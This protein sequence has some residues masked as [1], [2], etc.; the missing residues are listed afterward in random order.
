MPKN[1]R[2]SSDPETGAEPI[3]TPGGMAK[4]AA[5]E[6]R[7]ADGADIASTDMDA[8]PSNTAPVDARYPGS[9]SGLPVEPAPEAI[10]RL[11]GEVGSL[12]DQHLRLAAEFDNYRKRVARERAELSERAQAAFI[13]RL[14]D[15]L[16]DLDR[17]VASEPSA[18]N[19]G[20]LRDALL[21][22]DKKL[23]K[24][25]EAAGVER[26]DPVGEPFDPSQHEAVSTVPAPDASSDHTVSA[27]FQPGYRFKGQLVRPARVQVF[28]TQGAG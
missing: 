28:S 21:L 23:R 15:V 25:L 17:L 14:L 7:S 22:V 16:D 1:P 4:P 2:Y 13:T 12:R 19:A 27:T 6:G 24:E 18:T 26:I 3:H 10:R 5:P 20:S 9:G 8:N 11:E